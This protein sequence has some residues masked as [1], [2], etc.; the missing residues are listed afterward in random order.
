MSNKRR[1]NLNK[2]RAQRREAIGGDT[3]IEFEFGEPAE[4]FTMPLAGWWAPNF[5]DT[6]QSQGLSAGFKI[7]VGERQY[8]RLLEL[9][10][11][12][13]DINALLEDVSDEDGTSLPESSG[14]AES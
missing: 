2:K 5:T 3:E 13:G 11:L 8:R 12:D 7:L 1:I 10:L 6:V 4:V 9:G 14:S